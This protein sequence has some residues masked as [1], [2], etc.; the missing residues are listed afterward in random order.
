MKISE[1]TDDT[2]EDRPRLGL[3][4]GESDCGV[5]TK[6]RLIAGRDSD[7]LSAGRGSGGRSDVS[8][9]KRLDDGKAGKVESLGDAGADLVV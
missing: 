6:G 8:F 5:G 4:I 1:F 3:R 9:D 7:D 2:V